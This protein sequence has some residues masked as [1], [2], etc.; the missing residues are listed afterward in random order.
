MSVFVVETYVVKPEK[1]EA[2]KAS[3]QKWMRDSKKIKEIKSLKVF[4]NWSDAGIVEI[5]EFASMTDMETFYAR[6][7]SDEELKKVN[8]EFPSFFVPGT[9][10]FKLWWSYEDIF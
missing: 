10:K 3:L 7:Q 9:R 1:Q 6:V 8:Q 2:H 4:G 5:L